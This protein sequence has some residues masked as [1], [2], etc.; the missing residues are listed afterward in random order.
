[1]NKKSFTRVAGAL[2][3]TAGLA[4]AM[5]VPAQASHGG[6]GVK[7]HG[8]CSM[9]SNWKLKAKADDSLVEVEAEIDSNQAGQVWTWSITDNGTT[10]AQGTSTTKARSGSF[11]VHRKVANQAGSDAFVLNGSTA[12]TGETCT[13][14]VT[15]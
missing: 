12:S 6:G 7:N 1:M 11:S 2:T 9:G 5:T 4:F 8:Q 15:L 3:L 14:T 13:G 10:V